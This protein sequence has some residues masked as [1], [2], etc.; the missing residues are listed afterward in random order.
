MADLND[1]KLN[2]ANQNKWFHNLVIFLAP[3]GI[4]Y[5]STVIGIISA[6]PNGFDVKDLIPNT[7]AQ[8]ALVLWVL[9][10]LLDYLRKLQ[11]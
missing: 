11:A 9:N 8:G 6:N 4:L 7:F 10:S 1:L 5:L 2:T 3:L